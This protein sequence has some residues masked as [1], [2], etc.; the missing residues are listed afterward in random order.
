MRSLWGV[1]VPWDQTREMIDTTRV[2][3]GGDWGDRD[4]ARQLLAAADACGAD[5]SGA[6]L[7]RLFPAH[8]GAGTPRN[9]SWGSR[10]RD[11]YRSAA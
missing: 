8:P 5:L 2:D 11:A 1:D 10:R 7:A 6:D 4:L 3:G 9:P